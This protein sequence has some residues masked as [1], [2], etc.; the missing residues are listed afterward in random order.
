MP[1]LKLPEGFATITL[2]IEGETIIAP[3]VHDLTIDEIGEDMDIVSAQMG[4]W[5]N[6]LAAAEEEL[7]AADASYRSW[8]ANMGIEL[9]EHPNTAKLAAHKIKDQIDGSAQFL[10]H[11]ATIARRQRNVNTLTRL[12]QAFDKKGNQLQSRGAIQR[13]IIEKTGIQ[14]TA[15]GDAP[16]TQSNERR[17][18]RKQKVKDIF[19]RRSRR[20][21][22]SKEDT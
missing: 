19:S 4:Y 9:A 16:A 7:A 5:S 22:A 3:V 13:A 11:K 21:E 17:D 14:T 1:T 10:E 2:K 18:R 8:R 20:P 15:T 6:V 12:F